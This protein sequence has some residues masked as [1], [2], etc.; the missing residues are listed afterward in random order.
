MLLFYCVLVTI[1]SLGGGW[2]P[3]VWRMGHT[4][5]QIM[6]SLVAGLMLGVAV[7]HLLPHA[8]ADL[9]SLDE[10][11]TWMLIGLLAMFFMI[12]LFHVHQHS[13]ADPSLHSE[14][15]PEHAHHHAH[16]E[17]GHHHGPHNHEVPGHEPGK[18]WAFSWVGLAFG[19]SLHSFFDGVALGAQLAADSHL[20]ET[21]QLPGLAV[22]LVVLLHKPL[23]ALAITTLMASRG[24]SLRSMLGVNLAFAAI[25]PAGAALFFLGAGGHTAVVGAA[26]ALAAGVFVCI[27][28]ADILPEVSFHSHDRTKLS[29]ALL[30]GVLLAISIGWLEGEGHGHHHHHSAPTHEESDHGHSHDGHSHNGHHHSH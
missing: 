4:Q 19:L 6:M 3:T 17:H 5:M 24:W 21:S 22:F 12:R 18:G 20:H 14:V 30:V 29:V 9:P 13:V 26:L 15:H 28:L 11:V 8:A 23:D 16:C 10:A 7:L 27:A 2:L 1:A 25:C